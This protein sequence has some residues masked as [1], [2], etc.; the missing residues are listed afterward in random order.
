LWKQNDLPTQKENKK[1]VVNYDIIINGEIII[2]LGINE[3]F[4]TEIMI[5][6]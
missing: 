6:E 1:I 3:A 5:I 4:F 2:D